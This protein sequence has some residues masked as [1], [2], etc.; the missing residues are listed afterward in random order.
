MRGEIKEFLPA[1]PHETSESF[2][3][4]VRFGEVFL[5]EAG[6]EITLD[7][8]MGV[9]DKASRQPALSLEVGDAQA[10]GFD[11]VL[12]NPPYGSS[13]SDAV[14]WNFFDRKN[15]GA[16]SKDPYGLF[17]AR[18]LE[19]LREGD[20]LCF[21]VSTTWRTIKS[22][23]PLRKRLAT[24]TGV[25]HLIDL[26][27]WIFEAVV[28]TGILTTVKGAPDAAHPMTAADLSPLQKNDWA[29]LE[30]NLEAVSQTGPDVQT[31]DYARYSFPQSLISSYDNF[32]F[33]IG[34]PKLYALM[35]DGRFQKL[36]KSYV[37]VKGE[38]IWSDE[39]ISKLGS[40]SV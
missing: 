29:S 18:G 10:G 12:A 22:H 36:G 5:P 15:D 25:A 1:G 38:K 6:F 11:I 40:G 27:R 2:D 37:K 23:R 32:S 17:L 35:S 7:G 9:M 26:P 19:L 21:I 30:A 31:L 14:R 20:C 4:L 33:F 16:Q 13:I 3:W 34:S 24:Q 28:D 8:R 39:G